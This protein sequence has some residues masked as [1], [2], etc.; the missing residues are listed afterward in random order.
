LN[1]C[2]FAK[3]GWRVELFEYRDGL[4]LNFH[5][6]LSIMSII[7]YFKI[8]Y[9][10]KLAVLNNYWLPYFCIS[11]KNIMIHDTYPM[12]IIVN[13]RFDIVNFPSDIRKT[14]HVA[15]RSINLA[16]SLRGLEALRAVDCEEQVLQNSIPM[17]GRYVHE[18]DGKAFNIQKYGICGEV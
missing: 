12:Y 13:Q 7:Q 3:K 16:L 2:F 14:E 6:L 11:V 10:E 17:Y 15:G 9:N 18:K 5:F 8:T 1:A 4:F